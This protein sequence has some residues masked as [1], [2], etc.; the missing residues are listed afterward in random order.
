MLLQQVV[1]HIRNV[2]TGNTVIKLVPIGVESPQR[3]AF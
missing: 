3:R 2:K 1:I